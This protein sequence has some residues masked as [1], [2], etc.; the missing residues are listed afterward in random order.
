MMM[1]YAAGL[2]QSVRHS[3][4]HDVAKDPTVEDPDAPLHVLVPSPLLGPAV[5]DPVA[6]AL[7]RRGRR[8]VVVPSPGTAP[9]GP[10]DFRDHLLRAVPRDEPVILVPHSNAGLYVPAVV[11]E[12]DVVGAVF[13][14][15]GLPPPSGPVR[16]VPEQRLRNLAHLADADGLLPPWTA[17]WDPAEVDA[18]FPDVTTRQAVEAEQQRLPIDYFRGQLEA[19]AGWDQDLPG[20][21]L[22]FGGTYAAES[23]EARQRGW[24]VRT[25]QGAGHLHLL[26]DPSGVADAI[27]VAL[28]A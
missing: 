12:R 25:F 10:L 1:T 28:T 11:H 6:T 13:V 21:Y 24:R 20:A 15:A 16:M 17:W 22:A 23:A 3:P 9:R 26:V 5:W 27:E 4:D 18:L 2:A 7:R 19:P 14:D 8:A